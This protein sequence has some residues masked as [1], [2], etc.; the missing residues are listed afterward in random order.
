MGTPA[1]KST[2]AIFDF[3]GTLIRE[4]STLTLLL[5]LLKKYPGS[6]FALSRVGIAGLFWVGG[7]AQRDQVKS[8]V[9]QALRYVPQPAS[10]EFFQQFH[11]QS[12]VP[13]YLSSGVQRIEWHRTQGHRLILASASLDLYLHH[14]A[15]FLGF[16]FLICT[17]TRR[18]PQLQLA[19][20]NCRGEEKLVQM[21]EFLPLENVDWRNSWAY[22]DSTSDLPILSR[23]GHPVAVNPDRGLKGYARRIGWPIMEWA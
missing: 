10:R 21:S 6:L 17:R 15:Q 1:I 8:L 13:R 9:I 14:V 4:D 19:G 18:N 3:D 20:P 16:D 7:L 2:L 23:C 5:F 11:D 12:L 22:T